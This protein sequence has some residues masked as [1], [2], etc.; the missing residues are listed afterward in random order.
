MNEIVIYI[1]EF[2]VSQWLTFYLTDSYIFSQFL[3]DTQNIWNHHVSYQRC[4]YCMDTQRF[5]DMDADG[6]TNGIRSGDHLIVV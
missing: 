3:E 1:R 6:K 4:F 2:D 5:V